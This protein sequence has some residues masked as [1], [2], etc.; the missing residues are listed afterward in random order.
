MVSTQKYNA[1]AKDPAAAVR[2]REDQVIISLSRRKRH[3]GARP[4]RGKRKK[5]R[6]DQELLVKFNC[7]PCMHALMGDLVARS[8]DGDIIRQLG[9]TY[10]W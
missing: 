8:A 6:S 5:T 3:S 10:Q 7:Q 2:A 9:D 4:R 1:E